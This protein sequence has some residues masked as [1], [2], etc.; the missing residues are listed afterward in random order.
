MGLVIIW[1]VLVE[2]FRLKILVV[3]TKV[4]CKLKKMNK[5][6]IWIRWTKSGA[7]M[8]KLARWRLIGRCHIGSLPASGCFLFPRRPISVERSRACLVKSLFHLSETPPA[9]CYGC[10]DV[11]FSWC[12]LCAHWSS[13]TRS[14]LCPP[15]ATVPAHFYLLCYIT[16]AAAYL[17]FP[18]VK[19]STVPSISQ[20]QENQVIKS[21]TLCFYR[22]IYCRAVCLIMSPLGDTL[23]KV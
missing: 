18:T 11:N 13:I 22:C 14:A 3:V 19:I 20:D 12:T 5:E 15:L 1:P 6:K 8:W 21:D 16:D 7:I 9:G 17:R 10:W 2:D 23:L 4:I